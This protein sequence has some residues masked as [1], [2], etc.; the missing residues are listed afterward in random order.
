MK[1]K[2]RSFAAVDLLYLA[3]AVLP[4]VFGIVLKVLTATPSEGIAITGASVYFTLKAP[5]MDIPVSESQVNSVLVIISVL[6]IC[7]YLTHGL[8]PK[9]TLKRQIIAEWIVEQCKKL[10]REN[11][12]PYFMSFAPFICAVLGISALSSFMSLLGLFPPTSDINVVGGWAILVFILITYYK[13]KCGPLNYLKSFTEPV[14]FLTPLNVIS[15]VATPVSMAFRH[16]G[17]ILSGTVISVLVAAGL[18]GLS[19]I[20]FGWLPGAFGD[21]AFLRVGIP[22]VLSVYF[23]IFSG[24]LQA[25]IFAMLSMLYISSGFPVEEYEARQKKKMEKKAKKA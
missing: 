20:L 5:I 16:Y 10:V 17:N 4:F 21:I 12:G 7:L 11:M 3:L 18:G 23:D 13:M 19:D 2:S 1:T 6:G 15:E 9:P 22:A 24:A 8:S 25:F 14:A